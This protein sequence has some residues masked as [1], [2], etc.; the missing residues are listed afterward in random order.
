MS[1][2]IFIDQAEGQVKKSSLEAMSYGAKIAEQL[3]TTAEGVILGSASMENLVALGKY[4]VKK[5]HHVNNE[6]LNQFDAQL[7]TKVIAQVV[8]A[9][10]AAV[11]VFSNN[12]LLHH[13]FL[14]K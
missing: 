2:L 4:G 3:A 7:Y 5:I 1:V 14:R 8:E 12:K 11:V 13:D 10:G 9:C 6:I